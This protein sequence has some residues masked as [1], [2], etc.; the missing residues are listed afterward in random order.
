VAPFLQVVAFRAE[1]HLEHGLERSDRP[2]AGAVACPFGLPSAG[3]QLGGS[4]GTRTRSDLAPRAARVDV[5][6]V[7]VPVD[8]EVPLAVLLVR[9]RSS[10]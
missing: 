3:I 8:E 2:G 6:K 7:D 5:P 4:V 10:H 9:V 1:R